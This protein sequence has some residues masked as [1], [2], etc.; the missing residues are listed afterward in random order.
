MET[1]PVPQLFQQLGKLQGIVEAGF[2]TT[3]THLQTLNGRVGKAEAQNGHQDV[4]LATLIQ[5]VG[6]LRA[7]EEVRRKEQRKSINL[8][9]ERMITW[10]ISLLLLVLTATGI[11]N[12]KPQ[13]PDERL[14]KAQQEVLQLQQ[15]VDN[16]SEIT[17]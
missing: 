11:V 12:L 6:A 4:T 7:A 5:D 17:P 16:L 13:T 3:N 8:W 14:E 9:R 1:L 2:Q 10:G 15:E